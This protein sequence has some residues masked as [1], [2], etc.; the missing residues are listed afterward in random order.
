MGDRVSNRDFLL[1]WHGFVG[2]TPEPNINR[3]IKTLVAKMT[4]KSLAECTRFL[5]SIPISVDDRG[6]TIP[7]SLIELPQRLDA[8][9]AKLR[10]IC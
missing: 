5:P 3:I 9:Q 2:V 8:F 10:N 1:A 7:P 6:L 4:A